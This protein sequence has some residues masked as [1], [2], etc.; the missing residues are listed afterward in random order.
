MSNNNSTQKNTFWN[1]LQENTIEI[2]II[3]RDYAQG[4]EEK[5]FLRKSFLSDLK[6]SLDDNAELK[7]DFVYG[8]KEH[9]TLN[10]LD[11]QQR[12]TTLWLLHWYVAL[13]AGELNKANC[14]ILKRFTYETRISSREFCE[15]LCNDECFKDY[16]CGDIV[17]YIKSQ[18][19]FY[20]AWKQDPTIQSMLRMLGG[21]ISKEKWNND[22]IQQVFN[23]LICISNKGDGFHD[24]WQ[25]LTSPS[26]PI[27]FYYLPLNEFKLTDDL[28]IKMNA[29]GEQLTHFENFKADLIGYITDQSNSDS[30]HQSEKDIWKSLLHAETGIP[31]RLDTAWTDF[32]WKNKSPDNRIDDIYFAFLNRF[33]L[34]KL[35]CQKDSSRDDWFFKGDGWEK[36]NK[37]F[38]FLYGHEGN[39]TSL[40][41][42]GIDQYK[43]LSG[44][45]PLNVFTS[46]LKTLDNYN[47]IKVNDF[48][49]Q[50]VVSDFEFI[51]IYDVENGKMI[52][53]LGQRERI[54][55]HAVCRY[56]EVA[57][58]NNDS[59]FKQWMR[60]VWNIVENSGVDT[61]SSMIGV[62]RLI[63]ELAEHSHDIYSY[64]AKD[65]ERKDEER[66]AAKDQVHEEIAKAKQILNNTFTEESIINAESHPLLKGCISAMFE[67]D[68]CSSVPFGQSL[69]DRVCLLNDIYNQNKD[70]SFVK[71]LISRYSH[72]KPTGPLKLKKNHENWKI[73]VTDKLKDCF[74]KTRD[75]TIVEAETC[76]INL[77]STTALLENSREEGKVLKTYYDGKVVLW[78]TMGCTWNADRNVILDTIHHNTLLAN[79]KKEGSIRCNQKVNN[80]D[81]F[82]GWNINFQYKEYCFRWLGSPGDKELDVYLMKNDWEEYIY[83][84]N[85]TTDKGTDEDTHY[86][87]RVIDAINK[88]TFLQN[89]DH[90][91]DQ[92]YPNDSEKQV[93]DNNQDKICEQIE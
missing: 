13:K 15:N 33:F 7:L 85:K 28:Y 37:Y 38:S 48:F 44:K 87:F 62:M 80:C 91:I 31:N 86:C 24:Y 79:L 20:S 43:F 34:N 78:G 36:N 42:E 59:S 74:R 14:E 88:D 72:K 9:S 53:T 5:V 16:Q 90:L 45:I 22:G 21:T 69:E 70:Y 32:F 77:L 25:K 18:T 17:Q 71:V 83:R 1:F 57:G 56:F 50:W 93:C 41:Y 75:N 84:E 68:D 54:I 40:Q 2:P 52:S 82:W 55:F 19:W 51:P 49:P 63:D 11:G 81:F 27:V 64:L 4:R 89:L 3:Q 6:K 61:V 10:P 60:V 39:D 92:A 29:R 66:I 26:C 35:I 8:S 58:N 30:L 65:G 47:S 23:C 67:D 12:L 46:L 76:W 73:L